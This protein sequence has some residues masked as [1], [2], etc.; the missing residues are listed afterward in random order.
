MSKI[1]KYANVMTAEQFTSI[2]SLLDAFSNVL[3]YPF[4]LLDWE[5]KEILYATGNPYF[6]GKYT[7]DEMMSGGVECLFD[8][9]RSEDSDYL[10]SVLTETYNFYSRLEVEDKSEW[11]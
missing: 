11:I 4:Y 6:I 2:D 1:F 5:R 8:M 10:R 7:A 3:S 9:V